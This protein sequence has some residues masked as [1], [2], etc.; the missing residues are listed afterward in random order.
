MRLE[1]E[2]SA[3]SMHARRLLK[4]VYA[5]P[6][7]YGHNSCGSDGSITA[8]ALQ[9]T[10][11][12]TCVPIQHRGTEGLV[13]SRTMN[14]SQEHFDLHYGKECGPKRSVFMPTLSTA[15]S[16]ALGE[17]KEAFLLQTS[18]DHDKEMP[19]I[20]IYITFL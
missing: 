11:H 6:K 19:F 14:W 15:V 3:A 10:T 9:S 7:S 2:L 12:D 16:F 4:D 20:Y 1:L 18:G 17:A 5:I 13:A 8:N